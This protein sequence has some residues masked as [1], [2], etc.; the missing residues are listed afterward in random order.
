MATESATAIPLVIFGARSFTSGELL[1]LLCAHPRIQPGCLVSRSAAGVPLGELQPHLAGQFASL[2]LRAQTD[3]QAYE[4]LSEHPNAAIALCTGSGESAPIVA[5]LDARGLLA[6]RKLVDLSG[7]FRLPTPEEYTEW[8]GR[9]HACPQRLSDF[10]YCIPELHRDACKGTLVSNPGCFATAVQ[11]ACAPA[12]RSGLI[13]DDIRVFAIT[14]SSGSG[15]TPK[16]NTHHPTRAHE[17]YAYRPLIHQHTPEVMR[18]LGLSD[19]EQFSLVTHSA[20]IVRGITVTATFRLKSIAD[21]DAFAQAYA[22][23][24]ASEPMIELVSDTPRL[25]GVIGTNLVRV[26]TAVEGERAVAFSA[27]D[28]LTRGASG[29]ALQNL[30]RVLGFEET[31]GLT[32]PGLYPV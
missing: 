24:A 5:E 8:Y 11:V 1:R 30:N 9:E 17:L 29:Q 26:S 10:D 32:A 2:D 27:I 18:G 7:D 14:G 15:A 13:S 31:L 22:T 20:P 3:E 23:F 19:E 21:A 28:N 16:P 25:A 12:I 6:G 4:Y